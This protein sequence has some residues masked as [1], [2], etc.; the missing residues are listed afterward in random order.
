MFAAIKRW[1]ASRDAVS[2]NEGYAWTMAMIGSQRL[3]D[4]HASIFNLDR[5]GFRPRWMRGHT[6]QGR[7]PPE[8]LAY[9]AGVREAL[10][11]IASNTPVETAQERIINSNF[12]NRNHRPE[13]RLI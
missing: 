1:L 9:E 7:V 12:F 5:G 3:P 10:L 13:R 2:F 4:I 8:L 6:N 11:E